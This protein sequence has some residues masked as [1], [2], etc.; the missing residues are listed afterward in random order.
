MSFLKQNGGTDVRKAAVGSEAAEL[1]PSLGPTL[2]GSR[3]V[4]TCGGTQEQVHTGWEV[5]QF[6]RWIDDTRLLGGV[7]DLH[8]FLHQMPL[9]LIIIGL[10]ATSGRESKRCSKPLSQAH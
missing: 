1:W 6:D 3:A 10:S 2:V 5:V 4:G 8:L 7:F 9:L